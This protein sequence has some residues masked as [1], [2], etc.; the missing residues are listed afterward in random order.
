MQLNVVF[1]PCLDAV[2]E[3]GSQSN[4]TLEKMLLVKDLSEVLPILL[5]R[6]T[7]NKLNRCSVL[8]LKSFFLF[9]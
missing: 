8:F 2:S 5:K 6:T 9:H 4:R 1:C 7:N 3:P